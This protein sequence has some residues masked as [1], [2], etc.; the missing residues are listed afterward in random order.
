[1]V[2]RLLVSLGL[3]LALA[4]PVGAQLQPATYESPSGLWRL[5]V[6][7]I[8]RSGTSGADYSM[9]F[10]G[11][12]VWEA[13][14]PFTLWEACVTDEG[15]V[16][17]Y[18]Y[19][20]GSGRF[21]PSPSDARLDVVILT[22]RGEVLLREK[23]EREWSSSGGPPDPWPRGVL[24]LPWFDHMILRVEDEN[25]HRLAESWW[26]YDLEAG[27]RIAEERPRLT[28]E[29]ETEFGRIVA[30]RD[31]PGT[32]LVLVHGLDGSR[33][34]GW[35]STNDRIDLLDGARR[36][37][38][39]LR[40]PRDPAG[41]EK[42]LYAV[43]RRGA[44]LST[45]PGRFELWHVATHE[46]VS[47]EV[48][49]DPGGSWKVHETA[50]RP[51]EAE[52]DP[53][54]AAPI[55]PAPPR[56]IAL[57]EP[58]PPPGPIQ[59]VRALGFG[60]DGEP[61]FVRGEEH[62]WSLVRLDETGNVLGET[63]VTLPVENTAGVRWFALP[64]GRWV[65]IDVYGKKPMTTAWLV[66]E[67]DAEP[68]EL[69][70]FPDHSVTRVVALSDDEC[71]VVAGRVERYDLATKRASLF[72]RSA[73]DVTVTSD[74]KVVVL[75]DLGK[76]LE[77]RSERGAVQGTIV[78]EEAWGVE[79][80]YP[81]RVVAD[82]EGGVVVH[83][84]DSDLPLCRMDLDGT[85][86]GRFDARPAGGPGLDEYRRGLQFAPD[87]RM[88][89]TD[90]HAIVLLDDTGTGTR[91]LET[92]E[93]ASILRAPGASAIDS[94]FGRAL[95]LD[96]RGR[97]LHVF[98]GEGRRVLLGI[99]RPADLEPL[100]HP[101]RMGCDS[102]GGAWTA[103]SRHTPG[104]VRFDASGADLG[105]TALERN[106]V[107]CPEGEARWGVRE[108]VVL[109]RGG[110]E[111]A[112]DLPRT[113]DGR[114]WRDVEDLAVAADGRLAVLDLPS[115]NG[116]ARGEG[117]GL[118]AWHD[119]RGTPIGQAE[120]PST[121]QVDHIAFAGPWILLSGFAFPAW[122]LDTRDGALHPIEPPAANWSPKGF[123]RVGLSPD[124]NELWVLEPE[125]RTLW[126]CALP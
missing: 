126:R 14:H 77:I 91:T 118:V 87:G 89:T 40:L 117:P 41:D 18:G 119:A 17:G 53:V 44:L 93:D 7:P 38:W 113:A 120:I 52:L 58:V 32:P 99:P 66:D 60:A 11:T 107:F 42:D 88:W 121:V 61:R 33:L 123:L 69:P 68:R 124:G 47:Y 4:I 73:R 49:L 83:D 8:E 10:D 98:D 25:R 64:R 29:D 105:L 39:T 19:V 100:E 97:A 63:A 2:R 86:R 75:D 12:A 57:G 23:L 50:R 80:S 35:A 114:W 104:H 21:A 106:T 72:A 111:D 54:L 112:L 84:F 74:G 115:R 79:P 13:R 95:V 15:R 6:D 109:R 56:A 81:V 92:A 16:G 55:R 76:A 101:L 30:V 65:A 36:S 46:A 5:H 37:V 78:L 48:S 71:L 27:A 90:G 85:V 22:P 26:T 1:M 20:G 125:A 9:T 59:N 28:P 3:F 67:Q 62:G 34:R 45:G 103:E 102:T 96:R 94:T 70:G 24:A 82:A 51:A 110:G 31:V 108:N 122:L 43:R 116:V